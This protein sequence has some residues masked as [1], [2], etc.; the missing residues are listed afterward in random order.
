MDEVS[1]LLARRF[2]IG[3]P[4]GHG[5]SGRVYRGIDTL[6]G[7]PVAIKLLEGADQSLQETLMR[8]AALLGTLS[9]PCV[10]QLRASGIHHGIPFLVT[11]FIGGGSLRDLLTRE[12]RFSLQ[13]TIEVSIDL[14]SALH[15]AHQHGVIH[16]DVKPANVL[17]AA[18]GTPRLSDFGIAAL[19]SVSPSEQTERLIGTL[20][21]LSPE[22]FRGESLGPESDLWSLGLMV[23]E[24]LA[25]T[26]PFGTPATEEDLPGLVERP[27]PLISEFQPEAPDSLVSLLAWMLDRDRS[28]RVRDAGMVSKLLEEILVRINSP[29]QSAE[30]VNQGGWMT[31]FIGREREQE[32]LLHLLTDGAH[33]LISLVG[34]GGIGKTRLAIEAAE[35]ARGLFQDGAHLVPL[36]PVPSSAFLIPAVASAVGATFRGTVDP[37]EQLLAFLKGKRM[38]LVFDNMEHLLDG[39]GLLDEL[40]AAGSGLVFL[41]TSRERTGLPMETVVEIA[42]LGVPAPTDAPDP[43]N[44][45]ALMLFH[46]VARRA[47]AGF[48][49]K[50]TD[51]ESIATICQ[52]VGGNPLGI[53]L[54]AASVDDVPCEAIAG[55]LSED[56]DQLAARLPGAPPRHRSMR[57]VFDHSWN[58]LRH[59][60]QS[61]YRRLSVF[62]GGFTLE[63]ARAVVGASLVTISRLVDKSLIAR[64]RS[65]RYS[66]HELLHQYAREELTRLPGERSETEELHAEFYGAFVQKHEH[67]L[68]A[69]SEASV[70]DEIE[71]E[72]AN[73]R[74][75]WEHA[76]SASRSE[77]LLFY[78]R[79]MH[80][81]F[82]HRS[83]FREGEMAFGGTVE[84]LRKAWKTDEWGL[85]ALAVALTCWSALIYRLARYQEARDSAQ[86]ARAMAE[87]LDLRI[88]AASAANTAGIA[89]IALGDTD[90]A[91]DLIAH[92][93]VTWEDIGNLQG[94][95]ACHANLGVIADGF[96]R[97]DE[98]VT[99][100][101]RALAIFTQIDHKPG[102][103]TVLQN[104]TGMALQ[105]GDLSE[106]R[107]LADE[108]LVL[109]RAVGDRLSE[110]RALATLGIVAHRRGND[111]GAVRRYEES[112]AI[113][114]ALG[115]RRG[116]AN[117]LAHL[118]VSLAAR[119][120]PDCAKAILEEAHDEAEA[121]GD[122]HGQ[123][124]ALM[125]RADHCMELDESREAEQCYRNAL[126]LANETKAVP[127]I[128]EI[129]RA[130]ARLKDRFGDMAGA[131]EAFL[132][133]LDQPFHQEDRESMEQAIAKL[134]KTLAVETVEGVRGLA[135]SQ[136]LEQFARRL[137]A[138][139]RWS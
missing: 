128:V 81:F 129:I 32:H 137:L 34:P 17:M 26:L 122:R 8:E 98:A 38:L 39:R 5:A 133:G 30:G 53:E 134:E 50:P 107:R 76:L 68:A 54:A 135:A 13:W 24:M 7:E 124:M 40:L 91:K 71:R 93:L 47:S 15:H 44:H 77:L 60:E 74:G 125:F 90:D 117:T 78:L 64:N 23:F 99:H 58:L 63:A 132:V 6:N 12:H 126:A 51:W 139:P 59:S 138:E 116:L 19:S 86:E 48:I 56:I 16:R 35:E 25:G 114:R 87:A 120:L 80:R 109:A 61:I 55:R 3:D 103:A 2:A 57:A 43:A 9:H 20:A 112:V 79:G 102:K 83:R 66:V 22:G 92:A 119:G 41:V 106:T 88:D 31:P 65:N 46:H 101:E 37:K 29:G 49:P 113:K 123:T 4:I 27:A 1:G 130:V 75:G 104:L 45:P 52:L 72:M 11:D 67:G 82:E 84:A 21:Y 127:Q 33:R 105:R 70:F 100:Y 108:A 111:E 131:L 28:K 62:R 97:I 85:K 121:I 42:G 10:V 95:G 118:G 69:A 94:Q 89:S 110:S 136:T 73:I 18:D 115:D 96:G 14:A 36:A